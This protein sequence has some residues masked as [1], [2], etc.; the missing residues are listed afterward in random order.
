MIPAA[1][2]QTEITI[3]INWASLI[4]DDVLRTFKYWRISGMDINRRARRNRRPE[5]KETKKTHTHKHTKWN[6]IN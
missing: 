3:E 2:N 4:E 5:S 6:K 1:V